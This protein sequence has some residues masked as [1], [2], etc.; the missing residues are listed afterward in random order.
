MP[1]WLLGTGWAHA[2]LANRYGRAPHMLP[3]PV[4]GA[5][6]GPGQ[7]RVGATLLAGVFKSGLPLFMPRPGPVVRAQGH[8][9]LARL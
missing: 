4:P 9:R 7:S 2:G 3:L 5:S 8:G 6:I 1:E